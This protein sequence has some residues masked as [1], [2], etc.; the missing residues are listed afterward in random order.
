MK[1]LVTIGATPC[2]IIKQVKRMKM[3]VLDEA[4]EMFSKGFKEQAFVL[5]P[6]GIC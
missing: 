5:E 6:Q 4:D 2:G 1:L 3:L